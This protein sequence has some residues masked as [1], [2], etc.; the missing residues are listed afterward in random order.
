ML[1]NK[2][3][4]L[5]HALQAHILSIFNHSLQFSLTPSYTEKLINNQFFALPLFAS[6]NC[7]WISLY[8]FS[9]WRETDGT[10]LS[11][12]FLKSAPVTSMSLSF[13][14]G[15]AWPKRNKRF[16]NVKMC[17]FPGSQ[18]SFLVILF[19]FI[20][21]VCTMVKNTI[22]IGQGTCN[23]GGKLLWARIN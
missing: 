15:S 13:T 16:A 21:L 11:N 18:V 9:S 6:V 8:L 4:R 7:F 17:A 5:K 23:S 20:S 3:F 14:L 19:H 1:R 22:Q 10:R 12:A 2:N